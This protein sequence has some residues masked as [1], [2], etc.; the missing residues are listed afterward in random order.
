MTNHI[1]LP[2]TDDCNEE[3]LCNDSS[4]TSLT[5]YWRYIMLEDEGD[6]RSLMDYTTWRALAS[7]Y[8]D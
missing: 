1:N 4:H 5:C 7:S 2:A 8:R 6:G 3:V